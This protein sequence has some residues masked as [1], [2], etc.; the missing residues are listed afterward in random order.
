MRE[1]ELMLVFRPDFDESDTGKRDGIIKKL[2]G[3]QDMTLSG[4]TALGKKHLSYPIKKYTEGIYV[5]VTFTANAAKAG[6]LASRA[7]LD[8]DLLRYLLTCKT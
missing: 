3:S 7:K 1:Y 8:T 4:V 5:V 6:D 2:L